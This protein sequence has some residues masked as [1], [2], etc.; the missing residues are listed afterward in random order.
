RVVF[1]NGCFDLL[2]AGHVRYLQA[3]RS[4]GDFLIVGLNS[5]ASVRRLKG[6]SR[7]V[8]RL[9]ERSQIL[10][11]LACVD[12]IVAFEEAT[13]VELIRRIRPDVLTKGADYAPGEVVGADLVA[14]WGG[15]VELVPLEDGQSTTRM[16][17]RI[18]TAPAG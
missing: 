9:A 7:P 1:T 6:P 14:S 2:H 8:L 17:D 16:I 15:R 3:S 12:V 4:L 10:A 11:A 13:P 5:D 18:R